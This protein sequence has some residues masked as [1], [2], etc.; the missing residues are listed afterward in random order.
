[1]F[2]YTVQF[3]GGGRIPDYQV[4]NSSSEFSPYTIMNAQV[5]KYFRYWNIYLGAEN[6][7]DFRQ[8]NPIAG[9]DNPFGPQFDATNVWGPINGVK[10]YVGL[11]FKLDY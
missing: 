8:E 3:N 10:V 6:M 1:M 4:S 2:D 9:A 11:R 7:T 5:T